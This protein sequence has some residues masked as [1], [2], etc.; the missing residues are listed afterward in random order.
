MDSHVVTLRFLRCS[1]CNCCGILF[2]SSHTCPWGWKGLVPSESLLPP[3]GTEMLAT[4]MTWSGL[5]RDQKKGWRAWEHTQLSVGF[6]LP[7][8]PAVRSA[9]LSHL[10]ILSEL[11]LQYDLL[12][13]QERWKTCTSDDGGARITWKLV[14]WRF[15][16]GHCSW[17][18]TSYCCP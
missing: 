12:S 2:M 17:Q 6:C 9:Q 1:R 14:A 5:V 16:T 18:S 11:D 10:T 8:E 4:L 7:L 3:K 15:C 13:W